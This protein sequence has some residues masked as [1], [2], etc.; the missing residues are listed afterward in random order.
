MHL[1]VLWTVCELLQQFRKVSQTVVRI[2]TAIPLFD[3]VFG[4][5]M[6]IRATLVGLVRHFALELDLLWTKPCDAIIKTL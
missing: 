4:S 1:C 3:Y 5:L 6:V 2:S